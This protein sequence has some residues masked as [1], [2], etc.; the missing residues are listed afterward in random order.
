MLPSEVNCVITH[1]NCPDGW[2]SAWAAWRLLGHDA[3]YIFLSHGDPP[4]DVRGKNVL[5]VDF[6]FAKEGGE[7]VQASG[8]EG[9]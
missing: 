1:A 8:E 6:A 2:G 4:P 3:E 5:M 7:G 9:A